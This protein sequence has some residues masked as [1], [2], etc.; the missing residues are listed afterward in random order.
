MSIK[1]YLPSTSYSTDKNMSAKNDDKQNK[2]SS[3]TIKTLK[4]IKTNF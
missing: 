2:D 1:H 4:A 3:V